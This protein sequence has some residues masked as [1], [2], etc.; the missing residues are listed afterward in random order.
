MTQRCGIFVAVVFMLL[1]LGFSV[2]I[3]RRDVHH[4][5]QVAGIALDYEEGGIKATFELY[6]PSVDQPIGTE[7]RVVASY[8]ESLRDCIEEAE[9]LQ[10]KE[11]YVSNA[12]VLI[13][14]E[15][16]RLL[17]EVLS[18]FCEFTNNRTDLP[19]F[20]ALNQ[21]AGAL[22]A[23]EGEVLSSQIDA[24]SRHSGVRQTVLDL[25]NGEQPQVY[26]RGKGGFELV[27]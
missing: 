11:L 15:E 6:E 25:L 1:A 24:A 14:G 10:G 21:Q 20:V 12:S 27:S 8:G 2:Q 5:A 16:R 3:P 22:F 4:L 7:R 18:Y 17:E 19:I 13:L 9:K 26:L 23:G